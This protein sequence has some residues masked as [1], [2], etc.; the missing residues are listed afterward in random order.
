MEG[1]ANERLDFGK[2]G[3]GYF[4]FFPFFLL[5]YVVPCFFHLRL[6]SEKGGKR[7]SGS[8]LGE[9]FFLVVP[10]VLGLCVSDSL[11][12]LRLE[13]SFGFVNSQS[14]NGK[15]FLGGLEM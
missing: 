13:S 10:F 14:P 15:L 2:M 6:V 4:F 3:Y 1:S 5:F 8:Q 7:T 12:I 11:W 9:G